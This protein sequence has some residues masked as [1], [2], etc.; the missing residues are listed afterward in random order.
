MFSAFFSST[1]A[2]EADASHNPLI[3]EDEEHADHSDYVVAT[4]VTHAS[5]GPSE[6][7]D[8]GNVKWNKDYIYHILAFFI[9]AF[10]FIACFIWVP[11]SPTVS[12][13][14]TNVDITEAVFTVQQTYTVSNRNVYSQR[15]KHFSPLL[16]YISP[17]ARKVYTST[18]TLNTTLSPDVDQTDFVIDKTLSKTVVMDYSFRLTPND[19]DSASAQC[20]SDLGIYLTTSGSLEMQTFGKNF[21]SISLGLMPTLVHCNSEV[22]SSEQNLE[23]IG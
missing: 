15:I 18:G 21:D 5:I 16:K 13:K 9:A 14:R 10:T 7:G 8:N 20:N 23:L 11:R 6:H 12:V 22:T 19:A 2:E 3:T 17:G 1:S 4:K